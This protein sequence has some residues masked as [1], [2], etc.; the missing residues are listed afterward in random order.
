MKFNKKVLIKVKSESEFNK[1]HYVN[2]WTVHENHEA[3]DDYED[4]STITIDMIN[5]EF[6]ISEMEYLKL[7]RNPIKVNKDKYN[8]GIILHKW[9]VTKIA[10][11]ISEPEYFI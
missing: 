9:M 1:H 5:I 2:E 3:Y 11:N 7:E 4:Y 6:I 8:Q 10:D